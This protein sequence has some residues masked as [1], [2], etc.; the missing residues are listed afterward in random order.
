MSTY[1]PLEEEFPNEIFHQHNI[2]IALAYFSV[3]AVNSLI[4]TPLNIYMVEVL[5]A[6]PA[7]Q[8]TISILQTLPVSY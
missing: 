8:N 6:E 7:M 5:N 1:E 3:G 4:T 2:A